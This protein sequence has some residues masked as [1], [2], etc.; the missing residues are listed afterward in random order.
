VICCLAGVLCL[1]AGAAAQE[2][3]PRPPVPPSAP[4]PSAVPVPRAPGV[5]PSAPIPSP[6]PVPWRLD[7]HLLGGGHDWAIDV[8]LHEVLS[9]EQQRAIAEHARMAA[10]RALETVDRELMHLENFR[11]EMPFELQGPVIAGPGSNESG[12]YNSG[13][14]ALLRRQYDRAITLFDRV[15][16]QKGSHADAA[17]YW[18]AFSE[19][20]LVKTEEA[21]T[22]LGALRRDFPQSR[23]LGEAKVLEA[24]VKRLAGQR[25]DPQTLDANDELKLIA[26]NG[27][28]NTDPERAIP[29]LEGVLNAANTLGNKRRALF[30]LALSGDARAHQ[31]LLRY[32]KGAGN[33]ELQAEAIRNLVSRRDG[34]ATDAELREIYESAQD[35]A[36]RRTVI[37][38]YA[39]AGDKAALL[40]VVKNKAETV[41][42]KRSAISRLAGL[43]SPAELWSLYQEEPT[44]ALREQMVN[45]LASMNAVDRLVEVAKT[46][47]ETSIRLR[48]LRSL[49]SQN[50]DL[51]GQIIVGLYGNEM[52]RDARRAL[53]GALRS[54]SNAE[55]L[56][57]IARKE[58]DLTLKREIVSAISGLAPKNKVAADFLME[59]IK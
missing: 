2:A 11:Y 12:L 1:S 4:V 53:I 21:L 48:A 30:V 25:I 38:A 47:K 41:D 43:A 50:R 8:K 9:A 57:G 39:S 42:L 29:L 46:D 31:I 55:G 13:R 44:A 18:K 59:M 14:N 36:I 19:A 32:A 27:I 16:A 26:I 7:E 5:P 20:R 23:Y 17:L 40:G 22:T 45:A 10:D 37:E 52:D 51:T 35:P 58:T 56:V 24:D 3:T 49:G 28:A 34:R 6:Q 15:I 33:P 54:Q